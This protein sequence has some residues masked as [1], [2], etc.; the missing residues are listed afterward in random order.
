MILVAYLLNLPKGMDIVL[1]TW[2]DHLH[3]V[4]MGST[5]CT[6]TQLPFRL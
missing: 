4:A 2:N 5:P 3:R 1:H 6:R